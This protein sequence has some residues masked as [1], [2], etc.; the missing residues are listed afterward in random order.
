MAKINRKTGMVITATG[1]GAVSGA[2][3]SGGEVLAQE[4][5]TEP[6]TEQDE[7][8][9]PQP[10]QPYVDPTAPQPRE[11][12][13]P[14]V[15]GETLLTQTL[16]GGESVESLLEEYGRLGLTEENFLRD[17]PNF[18]DSGRVVLR[19]DGGAVESASSS[20]V[21]QP[22]QSGQKPGQT[23][24]HGFAAAS[25]DAQPQSFSRAPELQSGIAEESD[26][27]STLEKV[28]DAAIEL[29]RDALLKIIDVLI[30][31][32]EATTRD[33]EYDRDFI[34]PSMDVLPG[35]AGGGGSVTV[36][37][38]AP[39][40]SVNVSFNGQSVP[41]QTP[42]IAPTTSGEMPIWHDQTPAATNQPDEV[43]AETSLDMSPIPQSYSDVLASI[44]EP[45]D[46]ALVQELKKISVRSPGGLRERSKGYAEK[47]DWLE[48]HARQY[49]TPQ[50]YL[51]FANDGI[52]T[53]LAELDVFKNERSSKEL[54]GSCIVFHWM[55]GM[56]PSAEDAAKWMAARDITASANY[57]TMEDGT[58]H[59]AM[60]N[61]RNVAY[62]AGPEINYDCW[63]VEKEGN[64]ALDF[65]IR[66]VVS[67]AMLIL[68]RHQEAGMPLE[69]NVVAIEAL[70][71]D[72]YNDWA[73]SNV[74]DRSIFGSVQAHKEAPRANGK[75]DALSRYVNLIYSLAKQLDADLDAYQRQVAAGQQA[76]QAYRAI[77]QNEAL[78][79]VLVVDGQ[80]ILE[81]M[82][83][84]GR[85]FNVNDSHNMLRGA[86]YGPGFDGSYYHQGWDVKAAL[87][88]QLYAPLTGKVHIM[89]DSGGLGNVVMIEAENGMVMQLSHLLNYAEGLEN[90]QL[91]T[92]GSPIGHVGS[93]G[94]ATGPHLDIKIAKFTGTIRPF[95]AQTGDGFTALN[96]ANYFPEDLVTYNYAGR[97]DKGILG[98][99]PDVNRQ[100][101]LYLLTEY[102]DQVTPASSVETP[103][104]TTPQIRGATQGSGQA[105]FSNEPIVMTR[106][107][108]EL[109]Q[110]AAMA[111]TGSDS[112]SNVRGLLM[113]QQ[114]IATPTELRLVPSP[115]NPGSNPLNRESVT[116]VDAIE[117]ITPILSDE[118]KSYEPR[119]PD[120]AEQLS[121]KKDYGPAIEPSD[122]YFSIRA[123]GGT[124][125]EAA[126]FSGLTGRESGWRP[127]AV[128]DMN[129]DFF[130]YGLSQI[131]DF[132]EGIPQRDASY[133]LDPFYSLLHTWEMYQ[134]HGSGDR[135][136]KPWRSTLPRSLTVDGLHEAIRLPSD[137][138]SPSRRQAVDAQTRKIAE[139]V[140]SELV[141][142]EQEYQVFLKGGLLAA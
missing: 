58:V 19:L 53:S 113:P 99:D 75:I 91:V 111:Q 59:Q 4:P 126:L 11:D 13:E 41:T 6:N 50:N 48:E 131:R 65:T 128:G 101:P 35:F 66:G 34:P 106:A 10:E 100:L 141:L 86:D 23:G 104:D 57:F 134:E 102:Q 123:F 76:P 122:V 117:A 20:Y 87:G 107:Q 42:Q 51:A 47:V 44:Q 95:S 124:I 37:S 89:P 67:D 26:D 92:A 63:G 138:L 114:S 77:E 25:Q 90:G 121:I 135:G 30:I 21:E 88:D 74:Q 16:I 70:G 105:V 118:I 137:N 56:A 115:E 130:S 2:F 64:D 27:R 140:M 84:L 112:A 85:P 73:T 39:G 96:P 24:I 109:M 142:M 68:Q 1:I 36:T 38:N 81:V 60:P 129:S 61:D 71:L 8:Q 18:P 28:T 17:N 33:D 82:S 14:T 108:Y 78:E 127:G 79:G 54:S 80:P 97:A 29:G 49:V 120:Q 94:K 9:A 125:E 83:P 136:L 119:T 62:H 32:D 40:V 22:T 116:K 132:N 15:D 3:P 139:R 72:H 69:R 55:A 7:S 46:T 93:T 103:P 43:V 98:R 12:I 5:A 45:P 31:G 110:R 133:N 52:D